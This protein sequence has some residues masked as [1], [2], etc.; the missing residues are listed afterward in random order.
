MSVCQASGARPIH[1]AA[2]Y[3]R[4]RLSDA[5]AVVD[6]A[7]RH[8]LA[9]SAEDLDAGDCGLIETRDSPVFMRLLWM[10]FIVFYGILPS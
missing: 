5:C 7:R 10:I 8:R 9:S 4:C 1:L 2:G 3:G 6:A